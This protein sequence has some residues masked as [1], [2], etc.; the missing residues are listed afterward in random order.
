MP[1]LLSVA[2]YIPGPAFHGCV[3]SCPVGSS[4]LPVLVYIILFGIHRGRF[5]L[6]PAL[7][8]LS[9]ASGAVVSEMPA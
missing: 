6:P 5:A 8:T 7:V 1:E 4:A 3:I 2:E 9:L